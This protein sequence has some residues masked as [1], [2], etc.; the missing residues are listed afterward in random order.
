MEMEL[1]CSGWCKIFVALYISRYVGVSLLCLP[2]DEER[3]HGAQERKERRAKKARL[4]S[5]CQ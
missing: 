5:R 3:Q 1:A 2:D 4:K